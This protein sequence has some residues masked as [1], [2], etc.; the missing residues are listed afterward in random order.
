MQE[1]HVLLF[2]FLSAASARRS[3]HHPG[4]ITAA[5]VAGAGQA[6]VVVEWDFV[7]RRVSQHVKVWI[8]TPALRNWL[9]QL[10]LT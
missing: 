2:S 5:V 7:I 4:V 8:G 1:L 3:S 10:A 6:C 9:S